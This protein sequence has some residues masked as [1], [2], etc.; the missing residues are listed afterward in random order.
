MRTVSKQRFAAGDSDPLLRAITEAIVPENR[1]EQQQQ[2]HACLVSEVALFARDQI[3]AL[4]WFLHLLLFAGLF[5]FRVYSRLRYFRDF[6]SMRLAKRRVVV[7]SWAYGRVPLA[8]QLFRALRSVAL[9]GYYEYAARH[10]LANWSRRG[11]EAT[12]CER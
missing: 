9:L 7:N 12:P 5:G 8:R 11:E 6:T 2:A 10:G 3:L 1:S 4:P